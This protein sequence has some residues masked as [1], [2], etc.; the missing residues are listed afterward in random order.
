MSHV[1]A[2]VESKTRPSD[3]RVFGRQPVRSLAYVE[4]GEGNGGIVLNVSEGGLA[5]QAVMSLMN[6]ELPCMRLQLA[7]SK[8]QIE[9]K[10]RIVWTSEFR[11]LAGVEFVDLSPEAASQIR[12][13]VSLETPK[14]HGTEK[15]SVGKSETAVPATTVP[16]H[17]QVADAPLDRPKIA[18][19]LEAKLRDTKHLEEPP[20]KPTALPVD[21]EVSA[22][23]SVAATAVGP[24]PD[25]RSRPSISPPADRYGFNLGAPAHPVSPPES[26]RAHSRKKTAVLVGVF[27]IVSLTIGWVAG[28]AGLRR[29]IGHNTGD[30]NQP[31]ETASEPVIIS[32][33]ISEIEVMDANNQRW[34]IPFIGPPPVSKRNVPSQTGESPTSSSGEISGTNQASATSSPIRIKSSTAGGGAAS[35]GLPSASSSAN[36]GGVPSPTPITN[37]RLPA[38]APPARAASSSDNAL[39]PGRLLHRVEPDYPADALAQGIEGTVKLYAVI[40]EDGTVKTVQA[41]SGPSALFP[42]AINAVSQWRYS[43]ALFE[44]RPVQTERQI[45]ITFQLSPAPAPSK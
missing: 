41:L 8:K 26:A 20:P 6:E 39:Q 40:N 22:A 43:P 11:K 21:P 25:L 29:V 27:A 34:V 30:E 33:N 19:D 31:V 15:V 18:T 36:A 1:F 4:L 5:V 37:S 14:A 12:E 3:R 9:A 28:R 16:A 45:T 17:S 44:G 2:N 24:G 35:N 13:W 38:A 42:A 10:G 23:I 7:H 32:P